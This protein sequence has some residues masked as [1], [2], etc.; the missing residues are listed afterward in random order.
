MMELH[1]GGIEL[2]RGEHQFRLAPVDEIPALGAAH[3]VFPV[4]AAVRSIQPH[5]A[6]DDEAIPRRVVDHV[7]GV[8]DR[9][10]DVPRPPRL[11]LVGGRQVPG[12]R[13]ADQ[14]GV[15]VFRPVDAVGREGHHQARSLDPV[16]V[17][18][19]IVRGHLVAPGRVRVTG[20]DQH[21]VGVAVRVAAVAEHHDVGRRD[22][23]VV[24]QVQ[25]GL[26]PMDA[27]RWIRRS[28][29]GSDGCASLPAAP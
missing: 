12:I 17:H 14:W 10:R 6:V 3:G 8:R 29:P 24:V 5:L 16:V 2:I 9:Q 7:H 15:R 21:R 28:R 26:G 11:I 1:P 25:V 13:R 18:R 19:E 22:P 27:I 4:H 20:I 23:V